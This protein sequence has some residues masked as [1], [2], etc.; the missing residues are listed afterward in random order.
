LILLTT[1]VAAACGGSDEPAPVTTTEGL[2][3][4]E[5][6]AGLEVA[7]AAALRQVEL[8][9]LRSDLGFTQKDALFNASNS[10]AAI[11]FAVDIGEGETI[12]STAYM[13]RTAG[14]SAAD[15]FPRAELMQPA[16]LE[17]WDAVV[18]DE[19]WGLL[20]WAPPETDVEDVVTVCSDPF[21]DEAL[22]RHFAV[23]IEPE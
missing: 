10:C 14:R 20:V 2:I 15:I 13:V 8:G 11:V 19:E 21:L 17:E 16:F 6:R 23:Q 22:R 9:G 18:D 3:P 1:L 12:Y 5:D 7:A 4:P